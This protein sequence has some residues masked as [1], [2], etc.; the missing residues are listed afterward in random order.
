MRLLLVFVLSAS[1]SAWRLTAAPIEVS[2]DARAMQPGEVLLVTVRSAQPVSAVSGQAFGKELHFY[3]VDQ[4][5]VWQALVGVDLKVSPG[6]YPLAMTIVRET[7][8]KIE[9][10]RN[11]EIVGK[12]FPTRRIT[13]PEDYVNPPKETRE[14]IEHEA[15]ETKAI[16]STASPERLWK[17]AFI[18]PVEGS[19]V[20][21]FGKRSVFNGQPRGV[22][23]GADF[24]ALSGTPLKAP[25]AGRVVLT[26][27][28]YFAGN[29]II[30][31]H[32]L[33]LYSYFAHLS[34]S[35]VKLGQ[36]VQR[37]EIVGYTGKSGRVQGPHL[38]WS[39]VLGDSRVDPMALLFVLE[40]RP[41]AEKLTLLRLPLPPIL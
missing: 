15:A 41:H 8:E 40:D 26:K 33:G 30:I 32:G 38:H 25:A 1:M 19:I 35:R 39:V 37:G 3:P 12:T 31:D 20:S 6:G 16:F 7:G 14:R 11:L 13:V 28:L 34:S 9:E 5:G 23:S 4:A 21:A 22:H 29:A 24:R 2:V 27:E 10:T 36:L 18:R 17:G